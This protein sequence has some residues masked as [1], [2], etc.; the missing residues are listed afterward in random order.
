MTRKMRCLLLFASFFFLIWT[1]FPL[2]LLAQSSPDSMA[3]PQDHPQ[4]AVPAIEVV[5][6]IH[7]FGELMEGEV[8]AHEYVIRNTGEA[9]LKIERV[10]AGSGW[11]V[12][13]FD[14]EIPPGSKGKATLEMDLTDYQGSV[15]K[16][17]TLFSNDPENPRTLLQ[18]HGIV[19]PLIQVQPGDRISFRGIDNH[20]QHRVIDVVSWSPSFDFKIKEVETNLE[21]KVGYSIETVE[22]NR[23]YRVTLSNLIPLGVYNGFVRLKT[24]LARKPEITLWVSGIIEGEISVKPQ[25]LMVGK[26][27]NREE[28]RLGTVLVVNNRGESFKI[29]SMDYDEDLLDLQ[30]RPLT[31]GD[32]GFSLEI[33][34]KLENIPVG[35]QLKTVL[36]IQTE[37]SSPQKHEVQIHVLNMDITTDPSRE[38]EP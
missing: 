26:L 11:A 13:Q 30:K 2:T 14:P 29:I 23:H 9:V 17:A 21:G 3:L 38:G 27:A 10:S 6:P 32:R 33:T 37:A 24:D 19:N 5:N 7:D 34:P 22:E 4:A 8:A 20:L 35:K 12:I 1:V 18:M 28:V 25:T 15:R 31:A 16:S 36:S